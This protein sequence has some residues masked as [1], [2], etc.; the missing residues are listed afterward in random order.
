MRKGKLVPKGGK[1]DDDKMRG[2]LDN[3]SGNL[4]IDEF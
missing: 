3:V 4:V 1:G 2:R